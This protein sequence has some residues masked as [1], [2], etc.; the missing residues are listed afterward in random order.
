M[1]ITVAKQ[2]KVT[3]AQLQTAIGL[4]SFKNPEHFF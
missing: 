2:I 1:M 4:I 3:K